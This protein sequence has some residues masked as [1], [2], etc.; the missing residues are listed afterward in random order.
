MTKC[1]GWVLSCPNISPQ[2]VYPFIRHQKAF[3]I[4]KHN[5]KHIP[6]IVWKSCQQQAE[7]KIELDVAALERSRAKY[8]REKRKLDQV[9]QSKRL[10]DVA[11]I[12]ETIEQL[13]A[14]DPLFLLEKKRKQYDT[15]KL[16]GKHDE[17]QQLWKEMKWLKVRMPQFLLG[18]LWAGKTNQQSVETIQIYY[19]D[20]TLIA[21]KTSE[22]QQGLEKGE[23]AFQ[24][25]ISVDS[26]VDPEAPGSDL[27]R[28]GLER[29]IPNLGG[30]QRFNAQAQILVPVAI[31]ESQSAPSGKVPVKPQW[32]PG[33]LIVIDERRIVFV[34]LSLGQYVL[35]E[36][37]EEF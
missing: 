21:V 26:L 22:T 27:L 6:S 28:L 32:T 19:Q 29:V 23:I 9:I 1:C 24:C 31:G 5:K 13:T 35:F 3:S 10:E 4:C 33:E 8:F 11:Q 20:I 15:L 30:I 7:P 36:K 25:D 18:G 14:E 37:R 17:A 2:V 34:W 16:K 12:R